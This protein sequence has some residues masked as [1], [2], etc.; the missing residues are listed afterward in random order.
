MTMETLWVLIAIGCMAG[1]LVFA[2]FAHR[3]PR[4]PRC[5]VVTSAVSEAMVHEFPPVCEILYQCPQCGQVTRR[6]LAVPCD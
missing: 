5:A 4:C 2:R 3:P 6:F 1:A